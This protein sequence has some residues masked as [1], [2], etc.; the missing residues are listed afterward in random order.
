[1]RAVTS[2]L[3][4]EVLPAGKKREALLGEFHKQEEGFWGYSKYE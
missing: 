3:K 4:R 1:L 2:Q